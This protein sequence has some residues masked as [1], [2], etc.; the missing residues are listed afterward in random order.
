MQKP[1]TCHLSKRVSFS[2]LCFFCLLNCDFRPTGVLI[3]QRPKKYS[4]SSCSFTLTNC[5]SIMLPGLT[6]SII[7]LVLRLLVLHF[8]FLEELV[9]RVN[10][11]IN[12]ESSCA[13]FRRNFLCLPEIIS[14]ELLYSKKFTS[15]A[16]KESFVS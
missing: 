9:S 1:R 10:C 16:T 2:F 3:M 8:V 13:F 4:H 14:F 11:K 6:M 15:I 7:Q 5:W 12:M